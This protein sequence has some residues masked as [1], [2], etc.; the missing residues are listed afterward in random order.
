MTGPHPHRAGRPAHRAR[1]WLAALAA[2]ALALAPAVALPPPAAAATAGLDCGRDRD[3]VP[4]RIEATP[5]VLVHGWT[6][7]ADG[8][9]AV[10]DG[11]RK[12][13]GD[14][15]AFLRF[16]YSA[17]NTTWAGRPR[18]YECLQR[19]LFAVAKAADNPRGGGKV[20]VVA[21]SMGGLAARFAA[22]TSLDGRRGADVLGGV[23]TLATPYLGSPWGNTLASQTW[24]TMTKWAAK[25]SPSGM[26]FPVPPPGSSAG[27]CLAP[28]D[29]RPKDCEPL[30]EK[31]KT[32]P[33]QALGGSVVVRRSLFGLYVNDYRLAGDGIVAIDS[34]GV[35]GQRVDGVGGAA[36]DECLIDPRS[37]RSRIPEALLAAFTRAVGEL[38]SAAAGAA[39]AA[40]NTLGLRAPCSHIN[41]TSNGP[42][43]DRTAVALAAMRA[44]TRP[45]PS[46]AWVTG[47]STTGRETLVVRTAERETKIPPDLRGYYLWW[48]PRKWLDRGRL[49][50]LR[51]DGLDKTDSRDIGVLDG[52]T[53]TIVATT[54]CLG[55]YVG[56]GAEGVV[57]LNDLG[58][59]VEFYDTRLRPT[60]KVKLPQNYYRFP[61]PP[62]PVGLTDVFAVPGGA[63]VPFNEVT[64]SGA[65]GRDAWWLIRPD[66]TI[67]TIP[68]VEGGSARI[69]SSGGEQVAV[70]S[71]DGSRVVLVDTR[72]GV[73]TA[74][75]SPAVTA[76]AGPP[77][78]A[79]VEVRNQKITALVGSQVLQWDG[80]GWTT[81]RTV[82][83]GPNA[84]AIW[85]APNA[86]VV[87]APYQGKVFNEVDGTPRTLIAEDAA[88]VTAF[89]TLLP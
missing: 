45:A 66:G 71:G 4:A 19:Y 36:V 46:V 12:R 57:A 72:K 51:M 30:P 5:V 26:Q 13:L 87:V 39:G 68:Q 31:V 67:R 48:W 53:G 50:V 60:G 35:G 33:V 69:T 20:Y 56:V 22:A 73:A 47:S 1:R 75:P 86:R 61:G 6:S 52:A 80:S 40:A 82:D 17:A 7:N 2:G 85:Y 8:M 16:D 42:T 77:S 76:G 11:L 27:A 79:A 15:Y 55:C 88:S 74:L 62:V 59:T 43:L 64:P 23:V 49:V 70:A 24:E 18:V 81:W 63:L 65:R 25:G 78:V 10:R 21:H 32:L 54:P 34:A 44:R 58:Q 89:G 83:A 28:P 29:Q 37:L 41:I 14:G 3:P 38:T 84:Y 9:N